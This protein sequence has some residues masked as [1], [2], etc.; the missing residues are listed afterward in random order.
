MEVAIYEVLWETDGS[1]RPARSEQI[2]APIN[3]IP[4]I[5]WHAQDKEPPG[6]TANVWEF[7]TGQDLSALKEWVI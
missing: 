7:N 5:I 6:R 3:S 4:E 1:L 2:A